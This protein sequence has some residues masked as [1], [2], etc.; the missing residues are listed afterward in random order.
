MDP[1]DDPEARI[2]ELEQP[3]ADVA[4]TSEQGAGQYSGGTEPLPPMPAPY[5]APMPPPTFGVPYNAPP[6]KVSVGF[7]GLWWVVSLIVVVFVLTGVGIA[8][9]TVNKSMRAVSGIT[10][11]SIPPIPTVPGGGGSFT[12]APS[13][14]PT[15]PGSGSVPTASAG[16]QLSVAGISEN[17]TIACDGGSV[18]VSGV[19]N[20]VTITGHC[21]TVTVS[22][23]KNAVTVDS[24]DA[25]R[26]SGFNNQV[27]YHSGSPQVDTPGDS[28]VV[29]QG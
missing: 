13:G 25:I 4:R 26:A 8:I 12:K 23:M 5:T 29:G 28:N 15:T 10:V 6:R 7:G 1:E 22:G 24:A 14:Q 21:A 20:T 2:R 9:Y 3:L 17:K 11:P 18:S 27:T 19:T 16:K